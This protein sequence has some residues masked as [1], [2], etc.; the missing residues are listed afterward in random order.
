MQSEH[1]RAKAERICFIC[2]YLLRTKACNKISLVFLRTLSDSMQ[3]HRCN[4]G[5]DILCNS[6]EAN[7]LERLKEICFYKITVDFLNYMLNLFC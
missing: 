7:K 1:V 3:R 4:G 2:W 6:N 5:L